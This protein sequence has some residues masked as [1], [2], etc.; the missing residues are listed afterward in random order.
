VDGEDC[1]RATWLGNTGL[2]RKTCGNNALVGIV[3][4]FGCAGNSELASFGI[5]EAIALGSATAY[6]PE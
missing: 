3:I 4:T 2:G 1:V 5:G 6:R